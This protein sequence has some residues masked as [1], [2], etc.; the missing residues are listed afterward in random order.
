MIVLAFCECV[1]AVGTVKS[2]IQGVKMV[3]NL[4]FFDFLRITGEFRQIV[5]AYHA[6]ESCAERET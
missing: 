3:E 5:K 6:D 4:V 1:K 2:S